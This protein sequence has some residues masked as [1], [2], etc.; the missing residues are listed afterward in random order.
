MPPEFSWNARGVRHSTLCHHPAATLQLPERTIMSISYR[1]EKRI[2]IHELL[3]GRFVKHGIREHICEESG[4]CIP[5]YAKI[6]E[7]VYQHIPY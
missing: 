4:Q 2:L 5:A 1:P 6:G 7:H 3:D